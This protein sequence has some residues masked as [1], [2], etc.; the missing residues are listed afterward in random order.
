MRQTN[1]CLNKVFKFN[2][3]CVN[4]YPGGSCKLWCLRKKCVMK[5]ERKKHKKMTGTL[6]KLSKRIERGRQSLKEG[7]TD[8]FII[9]DIDSL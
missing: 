7:L 6:Y 3:F 2:K 8:H 5:I 4:L 1:V 9:G